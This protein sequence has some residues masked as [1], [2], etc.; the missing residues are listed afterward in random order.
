MIY[1]LVRL[2]TKEIFLESIDKPT[3]IQVEQFKIL[4]NAEILVIEGNEVFS[5]ESAEGGQTPATPETIE[6]QVADQVAL[7]IVIDHDK[8]CIGQNPPGKPTLQPPKH[9]KPRVVKK[10]GDVVEVITKAAYSCKDDA[11]T[12]EIIAAGNREYY[13]VADGDPDV[14]L[15]LRKDKTVLV[16]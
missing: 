11:S 8:A 2:D 16:A 4:H 3:E 14:G 12:P 1:Y 7:A 5:T 15:Y 6:V 9:G 10:V 13:I